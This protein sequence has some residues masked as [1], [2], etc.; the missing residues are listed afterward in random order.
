MMHGVIELHPVDIKRCNFSKRKSRRV[1]RWSPPVATSTIQLLL[2]KYDRTY[3]P[4]DYDIAAR[5]QNNEMLISIFIAQ[6]E[7]EVMD[8]M[9]HTWWPASLFAM[10]NSCERNT[11][12]LSDT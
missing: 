4:R 11:G 7:A 6:K 3:F 10:I 8:W 2:S 9:S 12:N 1:A 5:C